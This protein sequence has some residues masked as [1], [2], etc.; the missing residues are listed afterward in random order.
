MEKLTERFAK[1]GVN[2]PTI[3]LPNSDVD[4]QKWSAVACD[5]FSSERKYWDDASQF[6]GEAPSTLKLIL[7][8]CYLEDGDTV[9][10]VE[11]VQQTMAKY[12]AEK[13][14]VETTPGFIYI[15]RKTPFAPC[16][17]GLIVSVDLETYDYRP[18]TKPETRP[19]EGTVIERLPPRMDIRRE[20][21]LDMPHVMVL[22]DDKENTL[23]NVITDDKSKHETVYD[24]DLMTQGGSIV[25]QK[26]SDQETLE[27]LC[28]VLENLKT[29]DGFLFAVGD[30]NHSLAAAKGIW[31]ERKAAGAQSNDPGRYAL[32]EI[33]N[34][35]DKSLEFEPIHRVL[36]NIKGENFKAAL[37]ENFDFNI[38]KYDTFAKME[39]A[40]N[41]VTDRHAF[42][43]MCS[44]GFA[45]L[46][47]NK[48]EVSLDYEVIQTFLDQFLKDNS[49]TIIDYIHGTDS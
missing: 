27:Q 1:I 12:I 29:D 46:T 11:T 20:A 41:S 24:F 9:K 43:M 3:L 19:T 17:Q 18:G 16:R 23:F 33:E 13:T 14:I 42:G 28:T 36:F 39:T 32:V 10:R 34:I 7:P 30:G 35:Y 26:I 25:G 15:E 37:S 6:V 49:E 31:E 8:E 45:V 21:I 40:F 48:P 4:M 2:I 5:Q 22:V 38:E 44:N 47:I